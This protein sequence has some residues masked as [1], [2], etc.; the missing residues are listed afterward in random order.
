[1]PEIQRTKE[2]MADEIDALR[3]RDLRCRRDHSTM[4][5]ELERL[6]AKVA[7]HEATIVYLS[8]ALLRVQTERK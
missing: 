4:P 2:D 6:R 8:N 1:M 5:A 7:E 3:Q